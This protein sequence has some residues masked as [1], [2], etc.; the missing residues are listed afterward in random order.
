MC[1]EVIKGT[2]EV[3]DEWVEVGTASA[4]AHAPDSPGDGEAVAWLVPRSVRVRQQHL[5]SFRLSYGAPDMC[6]VCKRW[7]SALQSSKSSRRADEK[8]LDERWRT[9][10][11]TTPTGAERAAPAVQDGGKEP[12]GDKLVGA[13]QQRVQVESTALEVLTTAVR[14]GST[15][16]SPW[17]HFVRGIG[18]RTPAEAAAYLGST[19]LHGL[20]SAPWYSSGTYTVESAA[21][22][23]YN[24]M[25]QVDVVVETHFPG[26]VRVRL[27]GDAD[28]DSLLLDEVFWAELHVSAALRCV[29]RAGEK[30]V[31]PA[32][33]AF[34][35]LDK[36]LSEEE[37]FLEAARLCYPH[38]HHAG[39]S[40]YGV[41][42]T[43]AN[44]IIADGIAKY[45]FRYSRFEAAAAFFEGLSEHFQDAALRIHA[46]RARQ[47]AGDTEAAARILHEQVLSGPRAHALT[48]G[49]GMR[50]AVALAQL[51]AAQGDVLK[52]MQRIRECV[53]P[54]SK[55]EA[56]E[57]VDEIT[58]QASAPTEPPPQRCSL[59]WIALARLAVQVGQ[60]AEALICLNAAELEPPR[61]DLFLR[62]ISTTDP[63]AESARRRAVTKPQPGHADGTELVWALAR[64]LADERIGLGAFG[65]GKDRHSV[66]HMLAELSGPLLTDSER[67]AFEVLVAILNRVGWDDLLR[68]RG[69][70]FIMESDVTAAEASAATAAAAAVDV[71]EE[72]AAVPG[73]PPAES[74][75]K[76]ADEEVQVVEETAVRTTT[77]GTTA[78][79]PTTSSS[80]RM[81]TAWLDFLVSNLYE[82]LRAL[83]VWQA[84]DRE[85][86]AA[87]SGADASTAAVPVDPVPSTPAAP[88]WQEVVQRTRRAPVDWQR[89]GELALRLQRDADAERA[90]RVCAAV[91]ADQR[92]PAVTAWLRLAAIYT[93]QQQRAADTLRACESAWD[94]IESLPELVKATSPS[95]LPP[96]PVLRERGFEAVAT[97]GLVSL[98]KAATAADI[99]LDRM[100]PLLLDAVAW[101][102]HGF[103]R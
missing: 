48:G 93:Q 49:E 36:D 5:A 30:P 18:M 38:W 42:A 91:A 9:V 6:V 77:P 27:L 3:V 97:F 58:D 86:Q 75:E 1:S 95:A 26:G 2:P 81:C 80:K 32:L 21:Y 85:L 45:F 16:L 4:P 71:A 12:N 68:I 98:R 44:S 31:Y 39:S 23:A 66:D 17:F 92:Q 84:E 55:R 103:D 78:L 72:P 28:A 37:P 15:L 89:R 79:P 51:E 87:V 34:P 88:S 57:P 82:D 24:C 96:P 64:R 22:I 56:R 83:A 8:V 14:A 25:S 74:G 53:Q 7:R 41:R 10:S 61:M 43:A 76:E 99:R 67:E 65:L 11:R 33:K 40:V 69:E 19:A 63:S 102:V 60:F 46:A 13:Q 47:L 50:A 29:D 52:A 70:V 20:E 73:T 54:S 59:P 94:A 35:L 101:R 62:E 100:S 90:F